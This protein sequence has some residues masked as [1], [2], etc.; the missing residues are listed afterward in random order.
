MCCCSARTDNALLILLFITF[1]FL[2]VGK[3]YANS[4]HQFQYF[5]SY[6]STINVLMESRWYRLVNTC[7]WQITTI[8][9]IYRT[10]STSSLLEPVRK[11]QTFALYFCYSINTVCCC[12]I[13]VNFRINRIDI[14]GRIFSCQSTCSPLGRV[15]II[16]SIAAFPFPSYSNFV[17]TDSLEIIIMGA[18][19]RRTICKR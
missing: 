17:L 11:K 1:A 6:C 13:M 14:G 18:C 7:Q 19:G 12:L 2:L 15:S 8:P 4:F 5:P 16:S 10:N 9:S 3:Y